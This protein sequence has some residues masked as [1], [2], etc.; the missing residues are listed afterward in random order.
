VSRLP[1]V[2][3]AVTPT[4]AS[5]LQTEREVRTRVRRLFGL[6]VLAVCACLVPLC[7]LLALLLHTEQRSSTFSIAYWAYPGLGEVGA[8]ELLGQ[9]AALVAALGLFITCITWLDSRTRGRAR[10]RKVLRASPPDAADTYHRR[11]LNVVDELRMAVGLPQVDT[12][13]IP[14][15][16]VN[17]LSFA[18]PLGAACVGVSEG[19][20]ARLSRPQL[21][22]VVAHEMA[23]VASRDCVVATR[24][25][26]LFLGVQRVADTFGRGIMVAMLAGYAAIC[27][28][29]LM[30]VA[31]VQIGVYWGVVGLLVWTAVWLSFWI[32]TCGGSVVRLALSRQREWAADAGAVRLTS[33]P[34][35]LAEALQVMEWQRGAVP[36][37]PRGLS[38][39][40]IAPVGGV[41]VTGWRSWFETHPPLADRI[42]RLTD[43]AGQRGQTLWERRTEVL[44]RVEAR[45][46]AV[47][48]RPGR[49]GTGELVSV[50]AG[51]AGATVKAAAALAGVADRSAVGVAVS[52][53]A[54]APC[55]RCGG[56][57]HKMVY[58]GTPIV[59]CPACGGVGATTPQVEA[60]IARRDWGFTPQQERI[61]DVIERHD[62][63]V[64]RA[65][66]TGAAVDAARR[67]PPLS[68]PWPAQR[69][70]PSRCPFCGEPMRRAPWSLAYPLPTDSCGACDLHWFEHDELEVLQILL[71]RQNT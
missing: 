29:S 70:E 38:A 63:I 12:V 15:L 41:Q 22:A 66:A 40:S 48:A 5:F 27:F 71:E 1:R 55:P 25:S 39:L 8:A 47:P 23:H 13:V 44:R 17:A 31:P 57:L 19:A 61:A 6:L 51:A 68:L 14:A 18:D 33:D 60:I 43:L 4:P 69:P 7:V 52:D 46:H 36:A 11:L 65:A 32:A 67:R 10:L 24:A 35:S 28:A 59:E 34:A 9:I 30:P 50:R 54:A 20:L 45:E 37:I 64:R 58:E 49:G 53:P 56:A 42:T 3:A 62:G 26:L 2:D 16:S 21:Q